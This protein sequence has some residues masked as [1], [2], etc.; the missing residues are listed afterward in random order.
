MN[1]GSKVTNYVKFMF[2]LYF[3]WLFFKKVFKVTLNY[4]NF[5]TSAILF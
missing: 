5:P 4:K 2:I 1:I 3:I